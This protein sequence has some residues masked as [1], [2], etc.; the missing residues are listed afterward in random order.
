MTASSHPLFQSLKS[1]L[2][3]DTYESSPWDCFAVAGL[4]WQNC[5]SWLAP[6]DRLGLRVHGDTANSAG[7][8]QPK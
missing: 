2:S 6:F 5:L 3:L 7:N 4:P 1:A 8:G